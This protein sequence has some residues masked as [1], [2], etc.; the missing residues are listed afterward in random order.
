MPSDDRPKQNQEV[1]NEE[2]F[3]SLL[4][5]Y[6]ETHETLK[7][8]QVVE[9]KI[10]GVFDT[11]V[12]V[13]AGGRSEGVLR[14]DEITEPDGSLKFNVGD[15]ITVMVEA[16][17]NSDNQLRVSHSK[18][19]RAQQQAAL[20]EAI[21]AGKT[22]EGRIVEVVKGGLLADVGMR[23][24]IP[25]SQIDE[26]YVEDLRIYVGKSFT[27]RVM[28]HDLPN[29]KLILSRRAILREAQEGKRRETLATLAEG[30]RLPGVVKRILD[31]GV[32][33]D[34]GGVE[35]LLHISA[36]SWRRIKHPS[37]LFR[38]GDEIEVE[39]LK[40]DR[41][42]N[43]ISLGFRKAEDDP[44]L[45]APQLYVEGTVVKGTI[46][47][48]EHFGAFM[49]LECGIQGLI[50]ISEIS[51]TRRLNHA[52]EVLRVSDVVEAVVTRLDV[53]NRKMSLSLKQISAP[54]FETFIHQH[55]PG[56]ILHGRVTRV[57][58]YG[59]FVELYEGVE[60]LVHVSEVSDAAGKHVLGSYAPG[61]E[62]AVKILGIDGENK[63][64][65]LSIK[66]VHD[67][68]AR[69]TVQEYIENAGENGSHS[70]GESFP[71]ELLQKSKGA[72]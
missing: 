4:A 9:G 14:R 55:Q 54:P 43:R 3:A 21:K 11:E 28:Q 71:Q 1:N 27:F 46:K 41:E 42:R 59:L 72:D 5:K 17:A 67:E 48:L 49:E 24:F 12:L 62:V 6:E 30:Q 61:Q 39:V 25:A 53:S 18:A 20:R 70:L 26:Q 38:I 47:K 2:D 68:E 51:W 66:A 35:G 44:W 34:I 8:G 64:I 10:V 23:A 33:V 29:G 50:P 56:E 31:Y 60:G 22:L 57:M 13:D 69:A 32:F 16:G 52:D 40:F 15:S 19:R 7:S 63:K 58:D 36:M 37:E 45:R 65:A